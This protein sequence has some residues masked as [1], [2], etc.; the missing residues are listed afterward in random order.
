MSVLI[1]ILVAFLHLAAAQTPLPL[2]A[3]PATACSTDVT[4]QW[5]R[6]YPSCMQAILGNTVIY[7]TPT[8]DPGR[9]QR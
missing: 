1:A 3:D 7:N 5:S 4:K 9:L 8:V 2:P 6:E